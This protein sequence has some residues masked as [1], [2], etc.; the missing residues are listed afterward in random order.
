MHELPRIGEEH[1]Q[2]RAAV[3]TGPALVRLNARPE[4]G[5]GVLV[6]DA[7]NTCA[8]LLAEAPAMGVVVGEMTRRL[9]SRVIAYEAMAPRDAKGKEAP[10]ERW[11]ARG[12]VARR[13]ADVGGNGS[14]PMIGREVELGVLLGLLDKTI[15]SNHPQF[16]L[17]EGEAGIGKSRLIREMFRAVD[18]RPDFFCTWRQGH[19]PAY[20]DGLS[21]WPL[22]EIV[23]AH[24]GILQTDGVADVEDKLARAMVDDAGASWLTSQL[25]PL[26]G[27]SAP[28]GSEEERFDAWL[29]FFERLA[30]QRPTILVVED[31][32]WAS[33]Q[34]LAFLGHVVRRAE[35][36]PLLLLATARPE[37]LDAHPAFRR[38]E[39]T[40]TRIA[41]KSLTPD[42]SLRLTEGLPNA[43]TPEIARLASERSGGNPLFAEE[44]VR[45]LSDDDSPLP[46][47]M[48][49]GTPPDV[50]ATITTLIAA[51]LDALPPTQRALLSNAAVV[52]AVFWAGAVS[53]MSGQDRN[54]VAMALR[55][56]EAREFVRRHKES[57]LGSDVEYA[58]WHALTRDVAYEH[59]PRAERASRHAAVADWLRSVAGERDGDV[60][61]VLAHHCWTA[62]ELATSAGQVELAETL[63]Q[64]AVRALEA[65][66]DRMIPLDVRAA[67]DFYRR[68]AEV[69]ISAD[70]Q[71]ADILLAWVGALHQ[72]G[73][74]SEALEKAEEA[75]AILRLENDSVALAM[76]L[77]KLSGCC[78]WVAD[79]RARPF[80][81]EAIRLSERAEPSLEIVEVL[82]HWVGIC[83]VAMD[84]QSALHAADRALEMSARLGA[85]PHPRVLHFRGLSL[86]DMGDAGGLADVRKSIEMADL[87]GN[88]KDA[89]DF[90]FNL[91]EQLRSFEGPRS[92]LDVEEAALESARRRSSEVVVAYLTE[93]QLVDQWLLG[94]WSAFENRAEELKLVLRR[95]RNMTDVSQVSSL[96]ALH[97]LARGAG[98]EAEDAASVAEARNAAIAVR[99]VAELDQFGG[100]VLL[101]L[102]AS[103]NNVESVLHW[104]DVLDSSAR[105]HATGGGLSLFFPEA[106]RQLVALSRRLGDVAVAA[107][108]VL[109]R[110]PDWLGGDRQSDRAAINTVR[111][112][113]AELTGGLE[114]AT[115]LYREAAR[116][117]DHMGVPY[118]HAQALTGLGR[119]LTALK[120]KAAAEPVLAQAQLVFA[121]LGAKPGGAE[122]ERLLCELAVERPTA[123]RVGPADLLG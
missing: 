91:A 44:L 64:P 9:S 118:E 67:E 107:A 119:C 24:A 16:A 43:L 81:E 46:M 29:R 50:P 82:A 110:T 27:L 121:G 60:A 7:V 62:L 73:R 114:E 88:S 97:R 72:T 47:G 17:L 53:A 13:G 76:A 61:D 25:R 104:F 65:A 122:V 116:I 11:L 111:A 4:T 42:E 48:P 56:L 93:A 71:R 106:A 45:Y 20:G 57:I 31:V 35:G 41:V 19:C 99:S 75:V 109:K 23:S 32:H 12:R 10:V 105:K 39:D 115:S 59:L 58:F 63:R 40:V 69:A 51:R 74:S 79:P 98:R 89:E 86:C 68:A 33:N 21:L 6:G 123:N 54:D 22:R 55:E 90:A 117:W 108:E 30:R 14:M 34:T 3:N 96:V 36:I 66:G 49:D 95:Q 92:A 120:E 113:L 102:H 84:P 8:R 1:L 37:F 28:E 85:P 38:Y 26:V 52:G 5:E 15:A 2:V 70:R 94:E 80:A 112:L 18:E 101:A 78:D 103:L 87:Q 100:A 83:S 77:M